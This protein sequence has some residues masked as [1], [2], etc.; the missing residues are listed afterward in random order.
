VQAVTK[1]KLNL[2]ESSGYFAVPGVDLF[3]VLHQVTKPLARVL[4]VGTFASERQESY[5]IW[6]RWARYLAARGIE[7]L[8][9]DY[10]G[11]GESTGVFEDMSFGDWSEDV[12]LLADWTASR[13]P[14]VPFIL[15]GLELGAIFAAKSFDKG[16][17]DAL[18]LWS[19]PTNA[20]QVLRSA[21]KRWTWL[22]QLGESPE[23]RRSISD[24]IRQLDEGGFVELQGYYWSSRLWRESFLFDFPASVVGTDSLSNADRRPVKIINFGKGTTSLV[25]PYPKFPEVKD[26]TNLYADTF[27]WVAGALNLPPGGPYEGDN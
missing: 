24:S 18:L 6:V 14:R 4:L 12:R 25:M 16:V 26:L 1:T 11:T 15:H 7:V 2:L 10:R 17:G 22:D 27:R 20:N 5:N 23:N 8:R 9:F 13:S 21:L 19:V 3:T